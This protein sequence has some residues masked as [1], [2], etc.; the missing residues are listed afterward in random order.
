MR[1]GQRGIRGYARIVYL[2]L[3]M[4]P[5]GGNKRKIIKLLPVELVEVLCDIRYETTIRADTES[6]LDMQHS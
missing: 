1:G 5:Q 4:W 6:I 2:R 3:N